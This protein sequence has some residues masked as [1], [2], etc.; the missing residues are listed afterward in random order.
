M[1]TSDLEKENIQLKAELEKIKGKSKSKW[2]NRLKFTKKVS[3]TILGKD[4]KTSLL[5]FFTELENKHSVSKNTVS[6]LLSAVFMRLTRIGFFLIITSLLPTLFLL[7]QVYYLRNQNNL[8]TIQNKR[9]D[10]QTYLQE[11]DR[12]SSM[13]SVLDTM[14]KEVTNE[15][16]RNNGKISKVNSTRL[17]ALSKIL[18][19]YKYL[20]NDKLIEKSLSPERGYLLISLLE[21]NLN[22]GT[23]INN[24][25]RASLLSLLN[26]DYAEITNANMVKLDI[27]NIHLNHSN[28]DGGN[29]TKST[30]IK[31]TFGKASL[32]NTNFYKSDLVSCDFSNANLKGTSFTDSSLNK[33]NFDN[34]NLSD[35]NFSNC[36]FSDISF[37]N[38][39]IIGANFDNAIVSTET[40]LEDQEKVL[41]KDDFRYL[42]K[43][44]KVKTDNKRYVIVRKQ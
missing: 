31:S 4:L 44:F 14:I 36:D 15:G 17:I 19:P 38:S 32:Q 26:F 27:N 29:F 43:N 22:L 34:A 5:S 1:I 16:Y 39:S 10:Q 28:L 23:I 3:H 13:T 42:S 37:T 33:I 25:T 11:A 35:V 7:L 41:K 8:I 40:W 2:N 9:L 18:K 24:N 12:R 20:E 6:D 21:S 30:F